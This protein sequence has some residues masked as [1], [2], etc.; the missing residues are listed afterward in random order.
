VAPFK[1][2][3]MSN[4]ARVVEGGEIGAAQY[5]QALAARVMPDVRMNP[6]LVKPEGMT[7]S[8]VIVRGVADAR[9]S[10]LPWRDR[11]PHL[12]PAISESLHALMNE[13]DLLVLEG[14]GSPAEINLMDCDVTN[15]RSAQEASASVLL[16]A[17]IDRGGS[18]AHL[19]GT[20]AL[21]GDEARQRMR[22]FVLNKF[23][24][25]PSLLSPGPELIRTM[26]GV[27]VL[28]VIPWFE[29]HLPDEDGAATP[30][31]SVDGA[32]TVAVI[33]Y[34]FASNLDE[35][36]LL[37]QVAQVHWARRPADVAGAEIVVLPGSKNVGGDL[38]WLMSTG[39]GRAVITRAHEGARVLGICGG[40]Q[41]LGSGV[42]DPEG[43][44]AE[45][46]G[47]GLG[48]LP[49]E[50]TF[51]RDK[52]V[53]RATLTFQP[54][55]T[56]QWSPLAGMQVEGYEIRHGRTV[57]VGASR[58]ATD[59]ELGWV[60]DGVLGITV[61]GLFEAPDVLDALFGRKPSHSLDSTIVAITDMVV[62]SLDMSFIDALVSDDPPARI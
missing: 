13:Y 37:E 45:T 17:D 22:G 28:G 24:G 46:S 8:Q 50:T 58:V 61:H 48:L 5:F 21:V 14:A 36:K 12:W 39:V 33:R 27:P 2:Q 30:S 6:V 18:F 19:Y 26:T 41:M 40:L 52:L 25:D 55:L 3:N 32:T 9:I 47:P 1:A 4:N 51:E 15:W 20:W 59:G 44:E 23:R 57:A 31:G 29:H 42:R 11:S 60:R 34:P 43:I 38:A 49:V 10:Q 56:P 62:A 7:R 54:T 35:F 53:R 16:V